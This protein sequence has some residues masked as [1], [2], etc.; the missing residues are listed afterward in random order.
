MRAHQTVVVL[1][2]MVAA[3]CH[4]PHARPVPGVGTGVHAD[5]HR[6]IRRQY[7]MHSKLACYVLTSPGEVAGDCKYGAW[8]TPAIIASPSRKS[9][10]DLF[11]R[12]GRRRW[13]RG[14]EPP[15]ITDMHDA[16]LEEKTAS[17]MAQSVHFDKEALD[18]RCARWQSSDE[19]LEYMPRDS[20]R[21]RFG[22]CRF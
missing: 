21:F 11:S 5:H 6:R 8:R 1:G 7:A 15:N 19:Q 2:G 16:M 3:L 9:R 17:V 18:S 14:H 22:A 4:R 13:P 10:H 12:T 20:A